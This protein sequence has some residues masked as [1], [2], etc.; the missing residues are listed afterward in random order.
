M[1]LFRSLDVFWGPVDG[2]II[3]CD[4][5][6][7]KFFRLNDTA[8]LLWDVCEGTSPDSL[9]A[10]LAATFPGHDV[11]LLRADTMRFVESMRS[12]GL[13]KIEERGI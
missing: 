6:S 12:R 9:V 13:L 1:K 7:G 11:G 4:G 5:V 2:E 3:V 10:H 8:A